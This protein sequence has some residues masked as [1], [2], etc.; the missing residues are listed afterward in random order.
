MKVWVIYKLENCCLMRA[1]G[2]FLEVM[3]CQQN[4]PTSVLKA[5]ILEP[6]LLP[7]WWQKK[8]VYPS[9]RLHAFQFY[10]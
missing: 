3:L 6:Q 2:I 7:L 10:M 1:D 5:P 8:D 4:W 9:Q